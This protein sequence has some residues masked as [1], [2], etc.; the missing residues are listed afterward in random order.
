[1]LYFDE[2]EKIKK[3]RHLHAYP[4]WMQKLFGSMPTIHNLYNEQ[5]EP[6]ITRNTVLLDAGCGEKGIM[7]LYRGRCKLAVGTDYSAQAMSVNTIYDAYWRGPAHELP[8]PDE[9]FDVVI[10]Q[11]LVEHLSNPEECFAE[12]YRVLKPGGH[13]ILVTNSIYCPLM[14]FSAVFPAGIRDA[15]KKSLLPPEIKEDTFP[16]YYRSNSLPRMK[17]ILTK[18]GYERVYD[19]YVGDASFFIYS[20]LIFPLTLIYEKITDIKPLRRF[21]MHVIVHYRKP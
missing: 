18:I 20:R 1:M 8:Q 4:G 9:S 15:I 19:A 13:L 2:T 10:S 6:L 3:E 14:F 17:K 16:T 11:W 21:K 12:F 7:N 5:L